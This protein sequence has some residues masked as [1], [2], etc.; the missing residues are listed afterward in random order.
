MRPDIGQLRINLALRLRLLIE[1]VV[2]AGQG[3]PSPV[4]TSEYA[5]E[6]ACQ[7]LVRE[8][9]RGLIAYEQLAIA[10]ARTAKDGTI[11]IQVYQEED[12]SLRSG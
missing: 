10:D 8:N 5:S 6:E 12:P 3:Q 11:L 1:L 2:N 9:R 4:G 7:Q